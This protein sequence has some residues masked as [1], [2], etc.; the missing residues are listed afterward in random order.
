MFDE[1]PRGRKSC[2]TSPLRPTQIY[3]TFVLYGKKTAP[4]GVHRVCRGFLSPSSPSGDSVIP[5]GLGTVLQKGCVGPVFIAVRKALPSGEQSANIQTGSK[6][7]Y[8]NYFHHNFTRNYTWKHLALDGIS[9]LKSC[10]LC[11]KMYRS[12]QKNKK[13][14]PSLYWTVPP[15][16]LTL[17]GLRQEQINR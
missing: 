12:Y 15:R 16:L 11:E 8:R 7:K 1:K 6:K 9:G 10:I 13:S 2:K 3:R 14:T 17:K 4:R 5:R